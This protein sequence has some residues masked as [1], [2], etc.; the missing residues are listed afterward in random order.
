MSLALVAGA[1]EPLEQLGRNLAAA[2]D[3]SQT[4]PTSVIG[5]DFVSMT[6]SNLL[7]LGRPRTKEI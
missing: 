5:S 1:S 7:Q 3:T 2:S 4:T 6:N